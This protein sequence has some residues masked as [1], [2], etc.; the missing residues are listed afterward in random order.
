MIPGQAGRRLVDAIEPLFAM[1]LRIDEYIDRSN[2]IALVDPIIKA[3]RQQRRL[4][5]IHPLNETLHQSPRDPA[6]NHTIG[7][8]FTQPGPKPDV[9]GAPRSHYRSI[10]TAA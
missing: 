8:V 2:R 9:E 4:P 5:A 10:L 1:C 6:G 3:F 7:G